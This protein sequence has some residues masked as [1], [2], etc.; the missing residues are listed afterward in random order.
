MCCS[1]HFEKGKATDVAFVFSCP[2][3]KEEKEQRPARGDT[4]VNLCDLLHIMV[5]K[6]RDTVAKITG[7]RVFRRGYVR[8]TNA[9][10]KVEYD[11]ETGRTEATDDEILAPRNLDRLRSELTGIEHAIICCGNKASLAVDKL[12][13]RNELERTVGVFRLS[14]LGNKALNNRWPNKVLPDGCSSTKRRL[15]RIAR[16]AEC[17]SAQIDLWFVSEARRQSAVVANSPWEP[18]DQAFVDAISVWN[19]DGPSFV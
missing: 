5:E 16:V 11:E 6:H 14:H 4:G 3:Q 12:R 19:E 10:D 9:W 13:D 18:E 8:I 1:A 15:L 7:L 2:G 17:L